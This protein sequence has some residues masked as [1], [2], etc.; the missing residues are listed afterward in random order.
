[1]SQQT[2]KE[3]LKWPFQQEYYGDIKDSL[4][5]VILTVKSRVDG[6]NILCNEMKRIG[7]FVVAALNEKWERDF[8]EPLRWKK[9][10]VDCFDGIVNLSIRCPACKREFD[11]DWEEVW[12]DYSYCPHCGRWLLP[13]EGE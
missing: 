4:G 10:D 13:P 6:F 1:M 9:I 12:E 7:D 8:G 3:L 11:L 5:A 2:L